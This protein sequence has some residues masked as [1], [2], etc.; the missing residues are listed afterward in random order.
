[1]AKADLDLITDFCPTLITKVLPSGVALWVKLR[2]SE[3]YIEVVT[4]STLECGLIWQWLVYMSLVK[5]RSYW[6][7]ECGHRK[8]EEE[9]GVSLP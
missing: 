1:M 7:R 9:S 2:C 4:R 8:T 6:S 3:R 5:L